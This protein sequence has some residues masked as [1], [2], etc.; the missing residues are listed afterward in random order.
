MVNQP[1]LEE[2]I[3]WGECLILIIMF[4]VEDSVFELCL[5]IIIVYLLFDNLFDVLTVM[6]TFLLCMAGLMMKT[7]TRE[8]YVIICNIYYNNYI[9]CNVEIIILVLITR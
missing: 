7:L 2:M 5:V 3:A 6:M 9:G 4:D 1:L 8:W